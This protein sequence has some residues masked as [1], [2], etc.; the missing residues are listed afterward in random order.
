MSTA[1]VFFLF[2]GL[3]K[4]RPGQKNK[5]KHNATHLCGF[6]DGKGVCSFVCVC[7]CGIFQFVTWKWQRILLINT[8]IYNDYS[9][10]YYA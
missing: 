10:Y 8:V 1:K 7:V 4:E 2:E 3:R 9:N 6:G 5:T